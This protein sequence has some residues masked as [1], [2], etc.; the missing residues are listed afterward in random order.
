MDLLVWLDASPEGIVSLWL[1]ASATATILLAV[2]TGRVWLIWLAVAYAA[3][4]LGRYL[5]LAA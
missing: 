5:W 3:T 4:I 2:L 1:L